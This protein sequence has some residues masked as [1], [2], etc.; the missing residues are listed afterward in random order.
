MHGSRHSVS[1]L[2]PSRPFAA[3]NQQNFYASQRYQGNPGRQ[4]PDVDPA[5]QAKKRMA[6]ARERDLRN[7]HQEQQYN[8]SEPSSFSEPTL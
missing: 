2:D 6:Q 3:A 5:F 7:Y 8:R 1:D 4:V